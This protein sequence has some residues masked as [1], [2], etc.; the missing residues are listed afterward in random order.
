MHKHG[1]SD[2]R[3]SNIELKVALNALVKVYDHV[4]IV[5]RTWNA[6]R[7]ILAAVRMGMAR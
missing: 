1:G 5:D 6:A 3:S 2:H 7:Q 4:T